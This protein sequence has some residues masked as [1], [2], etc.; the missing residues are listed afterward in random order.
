MTAVTVDPTET[1]ESFEEYRNPSLL[2]FEAQKPSQSPPGLGAPSHFFA[3]GAA[4]EDP[5]VKELTA[6][7]MGA[8]TAL[9]ALAKSPPVAKT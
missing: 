7:V 3:A 1:R 5:P 8:V 6:F 9:K 4:P 2:V